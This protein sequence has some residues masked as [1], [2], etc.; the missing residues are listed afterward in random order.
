MTV[1]NA[2]GV[3]PGPWI[4]ISRRSRGG[5]VLHGHAGRHRH[6]FFPE[7]AVLEEL[8]C[9]PLEHEL[10]PLL[11]R[12]PVVVHDVGERRL[13]GEDVEPLPAPGVI[14]TN[15]L[16]RGIEAD[17][18]HGGRGCGFLRKR[19]QLDRL[20]RR[21]GRL[22]RRRWTRRLRS[23]GTRRWRLGY[24]RDRANGRE[25]TRHEWRR[26]AL[27]TRRSHPSLLAHTTQAV[28]NPNTN[29]TRTRIRTRTR[30]RTRL[31]PHST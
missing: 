27:P 7:A 3:A 9:R 14:R 12:V 21:R 1:A 8:S 18:Q 22:R 15:E 29:R 16:R 5:E 25:K 13:R 28:P 10:T 23:R 6:R 11:Q 26:P 19:R 17:P 4:R 31:P 2:A 30:T 24:E 20:S